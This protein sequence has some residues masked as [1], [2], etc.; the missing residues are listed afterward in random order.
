MAQDKIKAL[1]DTF[2]KEGYNMESETEFRK[3]LADPAKRKA[4][5]E[6]LKKDGYQ[7]EAYDAFESNI[8]Y[9]KAPKTPVPAQTTSN[10]QASKVASSPAPQP[11]ASQ[12]VPGAASDSATTGGKGWKP[13]WQQRVM[14]GRAI[15]EARGFAA[16]IDKSIARSRLVAERGTQKGRNRVKAGEFMAR[17]AGTPT[18]MMGLTPD[19]SPVKAEG[20]QGKADTGATKPVESAQSPVPYGVK[21]ID[22]KPV[23]QWLL[24]DGSLTTSL[25]E[26]DKAEYGARRVRLRN[27]FIGR[28]KENGLDPSKQ[29]D[30]QKQAQL[31]YEAPMRKV[32]DSV[33]TQAEEEDRAA[34]EDYRRETEEYNKSAG[35]N[36]HA[37]G[38]DGMPLPTSG[39]TQ[40]DFNRAVKRKETFNLEKM[41][42]KIFRDLPESYR[43]QTLHTYEEYFKSH[44]NELKG[45]TIEKAA[46]DALQSEVYNAVY[47]RAVDSNMPKSKTEFFMRKIADQ[48]LL[49]PYQAMDMGAAAMSRSWGM[50]AAEV[51]AMSQYGKEHRALDTAGTILN[52]AVDPT[53]YVSGA[54][55]GA[56]GKQALRF[57]GKQ[58]VK[59]ASKEVA[60]RF[61]RRTLAGR[62]FAGAAGGAGNFAT[63]EPLKNIQGQMAVGGVVNPET[64]EREFS[65]GEVVKAAAHGVILGGVTGTIAPIIGNVADKYVKAASSTA[66]KTGIRA[67]EMAVSTLA[68]G[69]I[70]SAYDIYENSKLADDDPGKRS[71]FDIWTDNLAMML[72]F[73]VSH[74]IKSAPQVIA[75]LRPIKPANGRPLTQEERNHNRMN[76]EERLRK[77]MDASPRDLDLTK[78]E[79]EELR[80]A[81]YGDLAEL[82][83]Y[84]K[85]KPAGRVRPEER[86]VDYP[87]AEVE[88]I[89]KRKEFDGYEAMEQL[90]Q[91][92]NVSQ[93]AR[94]KAYYILTGRSLPMSTVTGYTTVRE[95][96]G[97]VIINST[98][99]DGEVVTSRRFAD[100]KGAREEVDKIN[101]QVELNSIDVGERYANQ[102]IDLVVMD[103]V[104]DIVGKRHRLPAEAV[105]NIYMKHFQGDRLSDAEM[106][107]VRDVDS[108]SEEV[109]KKYHSLTPEAMREKVEEESGVNVDEA[110]R[111]PEKDRS[112]AENEAVREYAT[113]LFREV[114]RQ[115]KANSI[116]N[117]EY[118]EMRAEEKEIRRRAWRMQMEGKLLGYDPKLQAET[119]RIYADAQDVYERYEQG[120]PEAQAEAD[121]IVLRMQEANQI[122]EDAFGAE[123]EYY[124]FHLNEN[125]WGLINDP[126]LTAGQQD[127]VLYYINAKAALDGVMDAS[128]EAADRKRAEVEQSVAKRTHKDTGAIT[129]AT[130]KVNDR[131]VYVVKGDIV[132]FPDGTGVDTRNSSESIVVMDAES[133]KYEFTSP[134]Q[135]FSVGENIDPEDEMRTALET[136][137]QE[138]DAIFGENGI[139]PTEE[140]GETPAPIDG[141]NSDEN[142]PE[143]DNIDVENIPQ[144]AD[145]EKYDQGYENGI[146]SAHEYSDERLNSE[147]EKLRGYAD[148]LTDF[149]RRMLEAM[150]YAQQERAMAAE[151]VPDGETALEAASTDQSALSRI[152]LHEETGEPMFEAV[153]PET[154]WDGLV[155]AVEG[156]ANALPI[157]QQMI[158]DANKKL[159]ALNKRPPIP[160][161]P[162]LAG[163]AGPMA[164]RA[165]QKR[166]DKANAKAQANYQQ[167]LADAQAEAQAWSN[168]L[169]VY[170]NRNAE[171]RRQQEEERRQRDAELHDQGMAQ[172]EEEQRLKAEREAEQAGR[173]PYLPH[174]DIK[175]KWD[176]SPKF[177]GPET[178]I[179]LADGRVVEGRYVYHEAMAATPSHDPFNG[180]RISD[181]SPLTPN[182][183]SVNPRQYDSDRE[184][185]LYTESIS[186]EY[187][188][189][190]IR[191]D[192]VV[193][194]GNMLSGNG[195]AS[196]RQLAAQQ[197][198]DTAFVEA[199]RLKARE[200][201]IREEDFNSLEHPDRSFEPKQ[202]F[203]YTPDT[204]DIFNADEKKS[205]SRDEESVRH[206]MTVSDETLVSIS[207]EICRF[208]T[209]SDFYRNRN[210]TTEVL[211]ILNGA[212]VIKDHEIS[213]Y[214]NG[215]ELSGQGQDLIEDILMGKVFEDNPDVIRVLSGMRGARHSVL[216]AMNEIADNRTLANRGYDLG[217]ELSAAVDLLGRAKAALPD[218]YVEGMPVSPFGRQAGLFDDE[219]GDSRVTDA[220]T[221]LLADILNSGKSSELRK[222]LAAYNSDAVKSASGQMDLFTGQVANKEEILNTVNEIFKN[223]DAREKQRIVDE[224]IA[225]RKQR[226]ATQHTELGGSEAA[227]EAADADGRSEGRK[228]RAGGNAGVDG[229]GTDNI[230][231]ER[232]IAPL[233]ETEADEYGRPFVLSSDGSTTFG[234]IEA[235][236][237]L[238]A[239]PIRLSVGEN[240]KDN[241]GTNHGYGLLHIEAGHGEQIRNAG[242]E[243]VEEFVE[244]VA[245]NYETI[246]E[247]NR[248]GD[249]PTY[250]LEVKDGHNNT[251]FIQLSNDGSY[252]NVNSAGIFRERYSRNKPVVSSLPTIGSSSNAETAEVNHGLNEGAAVTSGNSSDT[253]EHK[254]NALPGNKQGIGAK[255]SGDRGGSTASGGNSFATAQSVNLSP[256]E[257]QKEAGNYKMG[258]RRI[259]GYNISIENPKG[260]VRR[261]KDANG[262]EWETEMHYDYGYIR[263]TEGVDGDHIDVFLSDTPEEGNVYVVDQYEPDGTF[264]EHKVMYGFP[265]AEAAR[266]AYLSN[267][268]RG[269]EKTRRIDLTGVTKEG[270]K[271]W[272]GSSRRKTKPFTEYKRVRTTCPVCG[273]T[274]I[275]D[276]KSSDVTCPQCNTDLSVFRQI[277]QLPDD[278]SPEV[279]ANVEKMEREILGK[280]DKGYTSQR[281]YDRKVPTT[282]EEQRSAI[283]RIIDFAKS[284]KNRV[285]R[286]VIGGITK[287]QAKDFADNGIE[288]DETWVH[289][290]ES[291]AVG[292]NQK[293]HGDPRIEER[294]GQIAI[295]PE[296]YARI[297]DI[298][299]SYDRITKSPNRSR[300]TGNEIIIYEKE[301]GDGYVYY[302]EEKRDNRKS[303]AFQTMYKKKKGTDSSDGLMPI[304]SPSTPVAPSDNLSSSSGGKVNT[305]SADKQIGGVESSTP[306][307]I[308]PTKY[309]GKRKTSDVWLVKFDRDL[310]KEEKAALD[311][312]SREPLKEGRK[313]SR[314]WYD[315]KQGGYMMRSEEAARQ[316]AEM[317]GNEEAVA[318][319]QPLSREEIKQ[320]VNPAEK[321]ALKKPANTVS[322]ENIV[323]KQNEKPAAP[324]EKP[325]P[326]GKFIVTEEMRAQEDELR[327]LLGIDDEEGSRDVYFR[328]PDELTPEE[329]RK[330]FAIGVNYAFNFLDNGVTSFP[331]FAKAVVMRLGSKVKPFLKSWYEGAKRVPGYGGEGYTETAE[332]D[333]FDVEN[334]D[335]PTYDAIKDAEM[336]VAER[337]AQTAAEQAEKELKETRNKQRKENDRQREADTE[338]LAEKAETVAGKAEGL[339]KTSGDEKELNQ[340]SDEIDETIDEI[341]DQLALLGYYEADLDSPEHEVY[342]LRRSAE[343]KA[344]KDAVKLAKQLV[345]DL[346][347]E[348][349]KVAGKTTEQMQKSRGKN[350]TAVRANIAQVGGDITVDLPY[351]D[352]RNLHISIGLSPTHERGTEP[353]RGG[354]AWEGDNYEVDGIM[355]RFGD[356]H[357]HFLSTDVTYGKMLDEIQRAAKWGQPKK[358]EKKEEE[359]HNGYKRGDEVMWDRYG[360]GKW[361]KVKIEDFD[362]DGSPIFESVK[363][364]MSEKGDWS[365]VKPADGVFGEAK[366]VATK[367]QADRA[368]ERREDNQGNPIDGNGKLILEEVQSVEQITDKDF[369][370]PTRNVV[371]PKL[372]EIVSDAIGADGRQPIIKKNIFEKNRNSHKDLTAEDGRRILNDVLYNPD[373]YGQNQKVRRP[374]NW[375]LV[376][377]ADKNSSVILEVNPTKE[378]LEIVNWHYL[379]N[380]TLERKKR[381]AIKEG[382]LILTLSADSAAA[383][384]LNG[385]SSEGK[386]TN[387]KFKKQIKPEQPVGNLFGGLFDYEP[388]TPKENEKR[389]GNKP[390]QEVA[391]GERAHSVGEDETGTDGRVPT[392]GTE[393]T[394]KGGT[395]DEKGAG[396]ERGTDGATHGTDAERRLQPRLRDRRRDEGNADSGSTG[397]AVERGGTAGEGTVSKRGADRGGERLSKGEPA[398]ESG[399]GSGT[400]A[401][402]KPKKPEVRYTSNFRYDEKDGNE[403]DTY[404]PSQR[405]EAN[406]EAIETLAEV[407]F[408][409]K[410]ATDEQ[411]AIMSRF[412]GW[413]Q[414]DLGKYYDIDHI[415]RNTYSNTPLNRLAKAIQKL[416]PQGDKKLFDAIKR[417]SLSSYYTPT[418][419]A[420]AMNT[421]LGLAGYKGGALLDPSMGNGMYEGTLPKSIQERTAITGVELDWLSGQLSR[422]LY[423]DANVIIGG[424]EKSGIAPGSFDV[425][426]SNVPFG[427][428]VVNDPSWKND[429]T[430][431]KRSAQNR[432][433]NYYAVKMLEATRPGG[434]VAMLTTSAVMDTPSNQNIRAHIADQGEIL[435][436]IRL[437]DNTFQGTG[438]VTDILFIRKW[439]DDQDRT[440]TREDSAYKELEKAFLSHFEKTA[441]NKLDGKKEKVQLNGYFEKNPR[442]LIGEIQ[443]GNQY[444]KRDAFGLTS[445]LSVE[446]IGSEIEKAIKRIIGSRRGSIFNPTRTIREVQQAVREAYKG[447]GDWVS[448][449]NLVIQD[450]KV[451]VLTAKSNEYGEVTRTFEGTLKHDKMLPRI[452]SMIEVRTAMKKLIAGQIEGS[453]ELELMALRTELQKAYDNFV[454]KYGRLQDKENSFI[455]D[456][457]DGYTIQALERWKNGKFIGLSDIFTKNSIKP[458]LKLEG[459]KTPQEAVALSL[460][461]YGYLRAAYL[462]KALGED[463]AE[464]CSDF[465]FLK[466]NSEDD[467]VTRDEYLSGDV[468][469]KLAEA[470]AAAEK[471]KS[472]ERNVKALEEVQPERIP[473]DDIAIHL[474]ARWIPE[475]ILNDFLNELFGIQAVR[476]SRNGRWDPEKREYIYNQKSGVRYIPE[477]DSFEINIEKKELGGAAQDWETPRKTA[478]EILQAALEDKTLLIKTKDKEGNEHI[479]EEQTEL[480]NQ[481]IADLR[482]RFESWLPSDPERVDILE[483]TYNDRFNRTVI[484]HFDGSHLVVPGLMGKELRPHQKDA[485]WMLINNRGGIVDHIVGAGKTLVMQSAIMEMRRM[486]IAKKPMI[487]ALK[488]TVSQIARE[489]KEAFPSARVLAPNDSDFK[490]EN[491]KKFIANISLN[492]YDCVILSHEQYCMLPHTEEAERAVIDEQ[493][494][495][496][497]NMIEYLYGTNDT[498]QMT[499]KQIKALEKRRNNLTATLEKRLDRNVDREFCFENLGVD[500]MF[501]DE[502]HQFKSLPYVTSYQKVAGLGETQGSSRA[503]ALLTG[504][505]HLQRMHQGDKGTVF[506]SGTTITN[507]LVEIYNLLN[508]LRPRKLEE[509]GMPTFDAWASTFAVHSAELE[510]GVTGTFAMKDRF[511]SFDNVPELSQLYAEIADVRNDT[512]LKLPKPAVDGRTVIVP[513]SDS[514]RKINAEIVKMLESKDGS[515]FGIYPKDPNRAPWGLH[516]ST[517]SAKAAVSPRL[518]FPDME[519]DGGKVH[520]V[521]ENVKKFY[522]ETSDQRGVQLIFCEMGVPEKGK[523]YDAYTDMVNRFVNNY[524]IPRSEIAYI[525]EANSEEKRKDLFQRVRDGKV[526]I[527]IGGTKNMGTG[528]NVQDRIT[529][530]HMLT[531]PWNP[532][533]LEQCI[534]RAARQGNLV[535]RDFMDN[536][537][538]VHYYA[539]EG[540]LDLY[541]YQLL[542]AKGKMF[543]Q[544]KMGTVNG[545]R[546]FDE[547]SADE[548]GKIDP[549]EVVAILSGNPVIFERAKQEKV[550]KKLR[551][552]RNGFERDY[553]RKK[554]KYTELQ[555][556]EERLTRLVRLNERDRADLAREGFKPDDKGVYP[557]KFTVMEGYSRYGGRTFD[558]PKEAGE[559]LL[560]ML[561]DGKDVTLQGFGQRAKVV[562]INEE[563]AGGLFST[564]RVL[565]IGDGE[566]DIKYTVRLSDDATA[567]G[568]AFRNLLK[569]IIDNGE[570]FK[571]DLEETKR[572][573]AGMN[574]G[575]GVFPK[576]AELDEAVA[577]F[578]ELNAEYNKLGKKPDTKDGNRYRDGEEMSDGE[579]LRAIRALEPIEVERNDMTKAELREVYNNLP[580][581]E[582]EGR[583]IEFYHSA[584]KKIYKDGGLFGQVVPVLDEV[585]DKSVLAY[586]ERDN[587]GGMTR[588]DGTVHKEHTNIISFDNYI[589]SVSISGKDYYVRLTVQNG[590]DGMSGLHSCMVTNVDLYEKATLR[591][592]SPGSPG[593]PQRVGY[594]NF[595]KVVDTKLQH[596]FERASAETTKLDMRERVEEL[597]EKLNCPVRIIDDVDSPSDR[598]L[599]RRERRAKGW[600]SSRT[601]EVVVVL[602]NNVNVAD[603]ENTVVHEV[604]GHKGLRAFIGEERFDEFLGEV[605]DHASDSIRKRIDALTERMVSEDGDRLSRDRRFL[606][607][608]RREGEPEIAPGSPLAT[609]LGHAEADRRKREGEYNREA[610]EEYMADLGGRIGDEGFEKM[611]RDELTLWGK[612]KAKVQEFLD[613]FLKGLKIAKSIRLTDKDLSYILFKSWKH[614]RE[615][616]SSLRSDHDKTGVFSEAEDAVRRYNSGW[617]DMMSVSEKR[618]RIEKLRNSE[619]VRI[620]GEEFEY[621]PDLK[622][623]KKNAVEYGK[624]IQVEYVN[625]DSGKTIQLQRGRR[626][627]GLK[628]VLQHDLHDRAHIQS[629]AAIPGIIEDS[630]YIETAP[631]HDREKN[632]DVSGYE[633]YVCGLKIGGEDYT[634]HSIVAADKNGNR[635]YDHKLSHIEKGK[636]LDFIEAKQPVE[637]FLTPMSGTEPTNRSER[638]VK[639][640]ISLLQIT[641]EGRE[642]RFRDPDMGLEE[643]I[644]KM[645]AEAMQANADNLEAKRE[646]MRAIG[647]NL[648]KLRQAMARQREYDIT[649]VKSAS[650]LA[651]IL[652]EK[653][654]LDDLSKYETKRILSAINNVVGKQDV[655]Q[656]VQKVMDIMVDNQL[657]LGANTLG[658][659]L[660]I[661]GSR[662]DA[663]G[664]E[665]QGELDP[666][667]Q[668]IAQVVRKSTSLPKDDID[669]RIADALNRMGSSD[670]TIADE[671]TIEYAGL[672]IARQYVEEIT[673]S[674]AE[675]KELRDS[676]KQAKEDK[677]AGQMTEAAYKQYV[678]ATND[679]IR[680]NKIERAE[681]F[682]ALAEQLGGVLNE[683]IERAKQWRLEEKQRVE[684]IHHNANSDMKGRP[685]DEHH[686]DNRIQKIANNSA[687]RFL[688]APL[689]TFDQMLRMF[690]GKSVR[691]EG[692]LWNRYMRGWVEAT[693]KEYTNYQDALKTLDAKVSEVFGKRMTWGDL[694]SID[695]K[696]PRA[697]VKFWDG[698][699]MKEH[700][701]TQGNL[702]Y[703]YMADKMSDGRMKLRRMGIT[704]EDVDNIRNFLDP[705]FITLADW[706]QE[707]FLVEKR[708]EYNEVH[709]RMFGAS[710]AAI[711]NYFPLKILSNARLEDVD[712]SE[713]PADKPFPATSTGSIIKRRR[714]N[715]A[716]D[717]TGANAFSVILDHLQQM[718][719]WAAF[720]E[721]NRDLNTLLSYKRFRNQVM[722]MSSVYGAGKT[723]WNN[724]RNVCSMAA[725]A[726]RPPIAALDK[727]AVN[728]AKGVTAAK[729][730]FRVFTALKQFLSLP[731]YASD[732]NP[733]HLATN[734]LNPVKAW[735]WS[736][737][738]LPLFE[739]RWKSRMA[740]DPRLLKSD[741]DWKMWRSRIVELASR[742]GMSPNA[743]VDALTVAIGTHSMY[744][745]KKA[746]YLRWGME[747]EAAEKRAKQDATILFNQTQQSS[748]GAFLSTMQVDRSWLSVLFTVFRNSS[749][750]YTRQLYDAMRN[751][752]HRMTLGYKDMSHEYMAKQMRRD[753]I[754][755]DTADREAKREYRRGIIRDLVRVGIFGAAL[756]LAWNLGAYLPYILLGDDEEEK[757]KMWD[758]VWTH[759]MFGSVEGLTGGDVMSA[760]GNMWASGE[761]NPAYLTKDMPLAADVLNILKKWDKDQTGA[762]N[763]VINL[764]VQ[765]GLGVNPQSLTDATV[766][767]MDFCG[768]DAQ[769]A[770][771]CALLI[772]RILNCPQSQID[773]IYFDELNATGEEA[774]R[775]TPQEIA[776]RF[777]R[778]KVRRGA[779]L[780]GWAYGNE[781][782]ETLMNKYRDRSNKLAKER[783]NKETDRQAGVN[784]SEALA[785]YESTKARVSEINKVRKQDE[786][787][788]F[789]LLDTLESSPEFGR[790]LIVRDYKHDVGDL[791]KQW[792]RAR[793]TDERDSIAQSIVALKREMLK[794]VR[795]S[796]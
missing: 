732:C 439:R 228:E 785:E 207:N 757:N 768:D 550:V 142:I 514:M 191:D 515:Y 235:E 763:D 592:S 330:V 527:L 717:V 724:F 372:P 20:S 197:G 338:A 290:F 706:M 123:S 485:V 324:A 355:F 538:R 302:L 630:I 347:I 553:Q 359:S 672:Q 56:A 15:G 221:L 781:T 588:P 598:P 771:E 745:T 257:A 703:I 580:T 135:I 698:G 606:E 755:P 479:D 506:L 556:R 68:E 41:A 494:W 276:Y 421:F 747:E 533:S 454:G 772:T 171:L 225:D 425:V 434:L 471:D 204:Y 711:E 367:A 564:H 245:R 516:A 234:G 180:F 31:D 773:K 47:Q 436:A 573:L 605:Y 57:G 211:R 493:L 715:L 548:D 208:D 583:E 426:T 285:E 306:Y 644:T 645:K 250:L 24:P 274:H 380:E 167:A 313:T 453:K 685:T 536:K 563:D 428:I 475:G 95:K 22:G 770:R 664:I 397:A 232:I 547:G 735:K 420:R 166:V 11:V 750:S 18:K 358:Q 93:A 143:N 97:S 662:V 401:V 64:G 674:K 112:E 681:S 627:G 667:G 49:S 530:A 551:A 727:S 394:G 429:A 280:S 452:K 779:P 579:R 760:A 169:S 106:E 254:D 569:R 188:A 99:A 317:I 783:I 34:D 231:E 115:R 353:K 398:T 153:D 341:N 754:D 642:K 50:N 617:D 728:I 226:A 696:L 584:F 629:V 557:T 375:I 591:D 193:Q 377:L 589:G 344:V 3:N 430:P 140:P 686:K 161:K 490:K 65:I 5:Y 590:Y 666:E 331:D 705:R 483:Q 262:K 323:E 722:N 179:T 542:D 378:S 45:R 177:Y 233:S 318:D 212:G 8:G 407:L 203:A 640:L 48:P 172:F 61:A 271:K 369:L 416:D 374:Y 593:R 273:K 201:G 389:N 267:Y 356:S 571:R 541:K 433:H 762:M 402:K 477:T 670:N 148:T 200:E 59:G 522:D 437:P 297:P 128:H 90:M 444:G 319:A 414:V 43:N 708:N 450:G 339:A 92:R 10:P 101:R 2:V 170:T 677:D 52:M 315:R 190:G 284:V 270:F 637:E 384:T 309:E 456:D 118:S 87:V 566:R 710:M 739:K 525:Q 632:P 472:F 787:R 460:A 163:K 738:N 187:D 435:G 409:D 665:V 91:D 107:I 53:A 628:E 55:G 699:E 766:A 742:V 30:V 198:T 6:A 12:S 502:S 466:P 289:S 155:E 304:A 503:V 726:Y 725:G 793:T 114:E 51:D 301:F 150:E 88:E 701:L 242:F 364:I 559:Y 326:K 443:A 531:V 602:P 202:K 469:A 679:A 684:E 740:G 707:D 623:F 700:E 595:D 291:S 565:Q 709:K 655:S 412:R 626:N 448:N 748:E 181:G 462:E 305:L 385:L 424:F 62:V 432:I 749:M 40:R 487:V 765:S 349:E 528:V 146:T 260:S 539:T 621:S 129:P 555:A 278:Q 252:W 535:A 213:K 72:G 117:E 44:T 788:Y 404:T 100:D 572:Q 587:L 616:K 182:G 497:N 281:K 220:T 296:D 35:S 322:I 283:S 293:H 609:A 508:Y 373:L 382:G 77:R 697:S 455:L 298:L 145:T 658:R 321:L 209:L 723:L 249:K 488:S 239:A 639:E 219:Y 576:Q 371:L 251:L 121:A 622:Q 752:G 86:A 411:R 66:G 333:R 152:P 558:K 474:G 743:F 498:S 585:L 712:I 320:A 423:P 619:P 127:A 529:D 492:D 673:E 103:E 287:R 419:I 659:L 491:R 365:R 243:S 647:G 138:R 678:E 54:V 275:P 625:K 614:A 366:R 343:K 136:I 299:E 688:L 215:D 379:S 484:R 464:Q 526:R 720:A 258:H 84:R 759:T 376:H 406:V 160:A 120:D 618:T 633:H 390:S 336:R 124:R 510:A 184:A 27:Q 741:M 292:H 524:G 165:E 736:M 111:R 649:T 253:S 729:V 695:R 663:R 362:A 94:A 227:Y 74:G 370:E 445:K 774:S 85:E 130:M 769:S 332:V 393:P 668:R 29:E 335:K 778:Y 272:I 194:D 716:L 500:Y 244:N 108:F 481:K 594:N 337:K 116:F 329:K 795:K 259:D 652:M 540:S 113:F 746:K 660:S 459:K 791:T 383:N 756:Q 418:P 164:M 624:T 151:S 32:L 405:L 134:E 691:G 737:K 125:P 147:I 386:V 792:L 308:T 463:W 422:M 71:N 507:S 786:E 549:A 570:V 307:T 758:D 388:E 790:Y 534:G 246:K 656:Y 661:R 314:G 713:A 612:I 46:Q 796:Q 694:F 687:V 509:L 312:F 63:Y 648:S 78:E 79:R 470:R 176:E 794:K 438:V 596:F 638:K 33:W 175:R 413:G 327:R 361:E 186:K 789:E 702:L 81:G 286:A 351:P 67:G 368:K 185:R 82:F 669:N 240:R 196:A 328:D 458:A 263:G 381:Q 396:V 767:V 294:M 486:G 205:M 400:A 83:S 354:G 473:F 310:S 482:E 714:N 110:L 222:M 144:S 731:A 610:T 217:A 105:E 578:K 268:E 650:D 36:I 744:Q 159:E 387:N 631:N 761:G 676:I 599:S 611:S 461:E 449:G 581:V 586:S 1:Y 451:G 734:L 597:S 38:P 229:E 468:V 279:L 149:G 158:E 137:E 346:G 316:L 478:K 690:G 42:D 195:G 537:V 342:G 523:Q 96:D 465:I 178:F 520:A 334:F 80:R 230:P 157:A 357:N 562:T 133:G 671:A 223:G 517:L 392:A 119:E 17:V 721:F 646:A 206:G 654:L 399:R 776:E 69:T 9:G 183:R 168:I 764:L 560:K 216:M 457:I 282:R 730:S 615:G 21:Y 719:R 39:E 680:Q 58:M 265:D 751:L 635:Y 288:V 604:V 28:M 476:S 4:A 704:E 7:M 441:P 467:Y 511:R 512:N 521:C 16:D 513:A 496:L 480:A 173:G 567:A 607:E 410:P 391:G 303:L 775:M 692:Y 192:K 689:A 247:G 26:A 519:D 415:L 256:T 495:Q 104:K 440:Q 575:D 139:P 132:M 266:A 360:N 264:D 131:Q 350:D 102:A 395:A 174:P 89:G 248:Y 442:N 518:I 545:G 345:E 154:A 218:V 577:K 651:R 75:S 608:C 340:V 352:G 544:F 73:K 582:K 682:Y 552:L 753:G 657:R 25:A 408:G 214:R 156:E 447:D 784:I 237:G 126:E 489:F 417:A 634:V 554:A 499:K 141:N 277:D 238:K 653:G 643:T 782:R 348:I 60:E 14:A 568:T 37:M 13:T 210:A 241:D 561:E 718:E 189:R 431:V 504:I 122:F 641:D 446:E 505:R 236:S 224:S 363:G 261:G 295:T 70:F 683:S 311:S 600:W 777:A 269:W 199:L 543:T 325:A 675:E 162:K 403:A 601:G 76:F 427:D 98:T 109:T 574:I 546:S 501:V 603:V 693:E 636:L 780:T 532:S 620:S 255:N 19:V 733:V 300:S 23:T 613:K